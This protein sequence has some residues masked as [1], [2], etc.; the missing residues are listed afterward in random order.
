DEDR[1]RERVVEAAQVRPLQP[2]EA[3]R[4]LLTIDERLERL[5]EEFAESFVGLKG[6]HLRRLDDP[7]AEAVLVVAAEGD[8]TAAAVDAGE[9]LARELRRRSEVATVE[10]I[11]RPREAIRLTY[12]DRDLVDT[13]VTPLELRELLRAHHLTAPGTYWSEEGRIVPLEARSRL[14]GRAALEALEIRDPADGD[15]VAVSRLLDVETVELRPVLERV[16]AEG[17]PAVALAVTRSADASLAA[18]GAAVRAEV[19]GFS[20]PAARAEVVALQADAVREEVDGFGAA[21]G[22]SFVLILVLLVMALGL[23]T[24]TAVALLV[25]AVVLTSV[26][27]LSLG[28]LSLDVVTL[29]SFVLVLGLLVDNHVVMA[30]RVQRHGEE[31]LDRP[32]AVGRALAAL[33]GP[34]AAASAT[35]ALGFLP[36]ARTDDV[37]G[38]YVRSL[39]WVVLATLAV[40]LVFAFTVTPVLV[41]GA[42]RP[43]GRRSGVVERAYRRL[44]GAS[45]RAPSLA[46]L[47]VL[48]LGAIGWR[49]FV[50]ADRI[51]FPASARPLWS[52]EIE[53]PAGDTLDRT[54]ETLASLEARLDAERA[55]PDGALA[56]AVSFLGRSA[57]RFQASLPVVRLSPHTAHVLLRLDP[58]RD[59]SR[60]ETALLD[61]MEE[62]SA[63]ARVRLRPVRLGAELEWPVEVELRGED[64]ETLR[65][66]ADDVAERVRLRGGTLV[67]HDWGAPIRKRSVSLDRVALA[68]S[69]LTAADVTAA[70]HTAVVGLPVF[71]LP[72]G[73]GGRRPVV[74]RARSD[75]DDREEALEDA[76]VWPAKG[77][78]AVLYEVARVEE[79]LESPARVRRGG[80][81]AITVL[82]DAPDE[83]RGLRL[84][85]DVARELAEVEAAFPGVE[86]SV[87]GISASAERANRALLD[88]VPL[89]LLLVLVL[90]L[91]QSQSIRET[92]LTLL[93]IPVAFAGVAF[94][95]GV[96]GEPFSFM[97]LVGMTALAGIVVNNAIVL[98]ASVRARLAEAGPEDDRRALLVD[99]AAERLRPILLTTLCAL[100]SMVVLHRS[101]GPMWQPL[102]TATIGGLVVST[103][104]VLLVV[105]ALYAGLFGIGRAAAEAG[106]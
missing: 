16:R 71:D 1:L 77:D 8:Q 35:T 57:P 48:V 106:R 3:L 11:G 14:D 9:R 67:H 76:Y 51:F 29:S 82:A 95:L 13:G 26:G 18:F 31:G 22:Q 2:H 68:E 92:L 86:A 20:S 87:R 50:E 38:D 61:W 42:P 52:I 104:V 75:R 36:V 84:E 81:P 54:A 79:R 32:A 90:L 70:I 73:R 66:A 25:P 33:K 62:A 97:T 99:A 45:V 58:G 28:G 98:L 65:R 10:V 100:A 34:L 91:L 83:G 105:P 5:R 56:G 19:A 53:R 85:E 21:L 55:A 7:L 12:D 49:T 103:L 74:L 72:D 80:R 89:A 47:I 69:D 30:E 23:R 78:P 39:F 60:L 63:E 64:E 37:I 96:T 43:G 15:P 4:E 44:L 40:S 6:P 59:P 17:R 93:T 41:R 94:G 27:L 101:G 88:E 24:G 102:A 46:V